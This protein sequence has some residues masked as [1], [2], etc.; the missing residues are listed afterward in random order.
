MSCGSRSSELHYLIDPKSLCLVSPTTK[1]IDF[2]PYQL[3]TLLALEVHN[4]PS[5]TQTPPKGFLLPFNSPLS[6]SS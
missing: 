6:L 3:F 2:I 4:S 1:N 5:F